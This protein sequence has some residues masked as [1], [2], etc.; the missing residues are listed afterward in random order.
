M[1]LGI[2]IFHNDLR[3]NDNTGL[4]KAMK[5]CDKVMPVFI[6]TPTQIGQSNKYRSLKSMEFMAAQLEVLSAQIAGR[7]GKLYLFYGETAPTVEKLIKVLRPDAI[8]S[9]ANYT[10]F[11]LDRD[12]AVYAK[13]ERHECIYDLSEDYGLY[14]IGKIRRG[15]PK[16]PRD[17]VY[18]K[19]TPYYNAASKHKPATPESNNRNNFYST[20]V[21]GTITL[22]HFRSKYKLKSITIRTAAS[23]LG[24]IKGFKTYNKERSYLTYDTTHLSVYLKFGVVS[25]REVYWQFKSL[26][27]GASDL[28][29]Q[30]YW[31]EFFMNI[32][33][34]F[35]YVLDGKN[36]NTNYHADWITSG[37][38]ASNASALRAWCDGKTGFPV[39]DACMTQLN[40]TGFMHNRGR[41]ITAGFLTK[42]LGWHW[43]FGERYF[44]T[45][46]IDYD[47]AQNN[48]NWQFVAGSGVDQQPY[49]RMFNP[50]LQ[51]AKHDPDGEYIRK[52][53]PQYKDFP[54]DVLHNE[55]K[56]REYI[57]ESRAKVPVPIVIYEV[58]RDKTKKRYKRK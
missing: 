35:P 25:A 58:A 42:V 29:K 4:I 10:P 7:G 14:E 49:F 13:C 45:R 3:L 40:E 23:I 18:K 24:S 15:N 27:K 41:L 12:S 1:D 56:L 54:T 11:A 20:P 2:F 36:F 21:K 8:Y 26:G 51:S 53:C 31:R 52:W 33:W 5:E 44:A 50:W 48:G 55:A 34:A 43:K 57:A 47:P 19:F 6:F 32:V 22:S 9:N 37:A 38:L 28:T 39:I 16:D 46:L 30:L 17:G